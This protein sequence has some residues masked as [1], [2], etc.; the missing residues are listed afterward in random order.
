MR[1]PLVSRPWTK[2]HHRPCHG[3]PAGRTCA[4]QAQTDIQGQRAVLERIYV[5]TEEG[6]LKPK[7]VYVDVF[8]KSVDASAHPRDGTPHAVKGVMPCGW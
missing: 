8:G 1:C 5:Q 6:F 2:A 4:A 3:D 7:V